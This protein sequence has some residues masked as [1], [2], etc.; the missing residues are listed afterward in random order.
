[1]AADKAVDFWEDEDY[2]LRQCK[3]EK[4]ETCWGDGILKVAYP[5]FVA[6]YIKGKKKH[7][8]PVDSLLI[9]E[10]SLAKT[11][12]SKRF[13]ALRVWREMF[14]R[15]WGLTGTPAPNSY[16]D[17]WSQIRFLDNG[18]RLGHTQAGYKQAYFYSNGEGL[19]AK[20]SLRPG[21]KEAI[22]NKISDLALTM[23]S[24]DYLDVPTC[25][26]EDVEVALCP[27]ARREYVTMKKELLLEIESGEIEALN[28]AALTNKLLQITGGAVY[29]AEKNVH[30]L[31]DAKIK[32]LKAL[33]KRHPGEPILVLTQFKHERARLMEAIPGARLFHEKGMDDWIAGKIPVWIADP[34]SMSHGIDG[35]QHGGRIAVWFTLTYSNETYIQ[36]NA[37]LVRTGQSY[38]TIVYRLIA[39]DT[40]DEAVVEALRDKDDQ[41]NGLFTALRALQMMERANKQK[42]AS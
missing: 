32:A 24:E 33:I 35:M 4:C 23:L 21:A 34:R 36:T 37:R 2:K 17:L 3:R 10:L 8:L 30:V 19:S 6:R 15:I 16:L 39:T 9:D 18:E 41:Q 22:E 1:M 28:A 31:H 27:K 26:F 13:N 20:Y 42:K 5:G 12:S 25:N 7:Q 14:D 29:D 38:E 40:V 11:A